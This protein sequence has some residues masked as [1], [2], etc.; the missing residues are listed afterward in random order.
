MN[1]ITIDREG[2][3]RLVDYITQRNGELD[4]RTAD[5]FMRT[6]ASA[7]AGDFAPIAALAG[8]D[9]VPAPAPAPDLVGQDT[10][11]PPH[12]VLRWLELAATTLLDG[13]NYDGENWEHYTEAR[14]RAR[15]LLDYRDPAEAKV[16]SAPAPAPNFR[17]GDVC[18]NS[19]VWTVAEP[20]AFI[21]DGRRWVVR[22]HGGALVN[23]DGLTRT[24]RRHFKAGER[25]PVV[26]P[27]QRRRC[28]KDDTHGWLVD[29]EAWP[30]WFT[31]VVTG[32]TMNA[33][34]VELATWP[35]AADW[36]ADTA[37]PCGVS[38]A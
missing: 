26:M 7:A 4:P 17:E 8:K 32:A 30:G 37:V 18:R 22:M 2:A 3:R 14:D 6:L 25:C 27:G 24:H 34:T 11:Y 1:Q 9:V 31:L 10:P 38:H 28:D 15:A 23:A 20:P 12:E 21:E 13:C 33:E 29:A 36:S 19:A 35:L 16:A 5:E